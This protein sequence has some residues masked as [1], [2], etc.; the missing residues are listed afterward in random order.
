MW[1]QSLRLMRLYYSTLPPRNHEDVIDHHFGPDSE[2]SHE[3]IDRSKVSQGRD[4]QVKYRWL[5]W[6]W[7]QSSCGLPIDWIQTL[8]AFGLMLDWGQWYRWYRI[9]SGGQIR[10][11]TVV[12]YVLDKWSSHQDGKL[13]LRLRDLSDWW[14]INRCEINLLH[15]VFLSFFLSFFSLIEVIRSRSH[16]HLIDLYLT[17]IGLKSQINPRATSSRARMWILAAKYLVVADLLHTALCLM[18]Q[19]LGLQTYI[20]IKRMYWNLLV[21]E[22]RSVIN[23]L[24]FQ[25]L[26]LI[27]DF[28]KLW[29][30]FWGV[31]YQVKS[32]LDEVED[33]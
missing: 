6:L 23:I 27:L 9:M 33:M 12:D 29:G 30:S 32:R 21:N 16:L 14:E 17:Y 22:C 7:S 10:S 1:W 5:H 25:G 31:S 3:E 13:R 26:C 18:T 2:T 19:Q 4:G 11:R 8:S 20:T 28:K 15:L 24:D